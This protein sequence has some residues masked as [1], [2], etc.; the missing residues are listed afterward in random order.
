MCNDKRLSL[1]L[2]QTSPMHTPSTASLETSTDAQEKVT[3]NI[4]PIL[5]LINLI[6]IYLYLVK[7]FAPLNAETA[8]FSVKYG[9]TILLRVINAALNQE[10]FFSVANHILTVVGNDA[11]YNK[12]FPT[13]V[14]MIGPGQTTNVLLTAN[15]TRGRYYM[16]ARAYATAQNAPFDNTTATAI[17]EYDS[18]ISPSLKPPRPYMPT[19][20]RFNDTNTV[21]A[22]TSQLRSLPSKNNKVPTQIHDNLFFTVGLGL[23]NCSPGPRCQGPNNTRFAASINNVSFVLPKQTSLLQAYYN[24]IPGVFTTDFPAVPPVAFDYTGNVS[25]RLWS[26]HHGTKMYRLKYGSNVQIVLQDTAIVSTEDHPMHLHGYHF[27]V[28]GQG[29]GNFNPRRDPARFNLV[30]PPLRNTINVPVGGWTVIRF[31]ADNPGK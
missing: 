17:L 4:S 15:Q 7:L 28:V 2:P 18:P 31:T 3:Y 9:E 20:P 30:D 14:I 24:N 23:I 25:R 5:A 6:Y 29:F 13:R 8:K 11:A 26:P 1:A 12:Q 22:Y 21:T 10:L 27:Y 19:F 16:A